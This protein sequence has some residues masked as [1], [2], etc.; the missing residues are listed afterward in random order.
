MWSE[1]D[2]GKMDLET[3]RDL[4]KWTDSYW[5]M[6]PTEMKDLILEYRESQ[7][8]IDRRESVSNRALC[9]QIRMY[10]RLRQRW[11]IGHVQCKPIHRHLGVKSEC[12]CNCECMRVYGWYFDLR[13]M[14]HKTYLGINFRQAM[15]NCDIRRVI[16]RDSEWM[17]IGAARASVRI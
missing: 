14:I 13:G 1:I 4:L 7:E 3:K 8:F 16:F 5:D 10:E 9:R 11:Q 15:T 2:V 12:M 17:L 6:L